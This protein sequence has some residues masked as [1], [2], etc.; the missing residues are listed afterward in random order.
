MSKLAHAGASTTAVPG[1]ADANAMRTAPF[2]SAASRTGTAPLK[3]EAIRSCASPIEITV[4]P[5]E[6]SAVLSVVD[7]G[8]GLPPEQLDKVFERF[9]R[10]DTARTRASGGSGLGLSITATIVDAHGGDVSAHPT[11]GGGATFVLRVPLAGHAA[12]PTLS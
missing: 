3:V 1:A 7:H 5:F 11:P 10:T 12:P 8:P 2:I 4:Q 6:Q 9:Y